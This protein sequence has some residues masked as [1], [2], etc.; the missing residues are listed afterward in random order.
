[1]CTPV[2]QFDRPSLRSWAGSV[3]PHRGSSPRY[4]TLQWNDF[5]AQV[6]AFFKELHSQCSSAPNRSQL[7]STLPSASMRCL[8]CVPFGIPGGN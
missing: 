2:I 8:V 6:I 3:F 7:A 4:M 5:A 1:M